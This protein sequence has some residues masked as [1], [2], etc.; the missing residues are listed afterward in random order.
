[1]QT[2][3]WWQSHG[4]ARTERKGLNGEGENA[5]YFEKKR[6]GLKDYTRRR[7]LFSEINHY[8]RGS[9]YPIRKN[10]KGSFCSDTLLKRGSCSSRG[11]LYK[12]GRNGGKEFDEGREGEVM[13]SR[14]EKD[15]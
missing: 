10:A 4:P 1:M 11:A 2:E 14:S 5:F 12:K 6:H 3:S 8:T 13:T 15:Y 9:P 7:W